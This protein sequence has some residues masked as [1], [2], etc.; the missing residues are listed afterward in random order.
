MLVIQEKEKV[1]KWLEGGIIGSK[2]CD[3]TFLA[4]WAVAHQGLGWMFYRQLWE[5]RREEMITHS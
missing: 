2:V 5:K 1:K 3:D 4:V